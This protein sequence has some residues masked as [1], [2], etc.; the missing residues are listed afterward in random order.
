VGILT[1]S[2]KKIIKIP[3]PGQ[4]NN[5]QNYGCSLYL[6]DQMINSIHVTVVYFCAFARSEIF[7]KNA[8]KYR[9]GR[10]QFD[11]GVNGLRKFPVKNLHNM[12]SMNCKNSILKP[13][14]SFLLLHQKSKQET[15]K[16][17]NQVCVRESCPLSLCPEDD[18][19][20]WDCIS[21]IAVKA[22]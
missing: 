12:N 14:L 16:V 17:S 7:P 2:K 15:T 22:M 9:V 6:K 5:G 8:R 19:I 10:G 13:H 11:A 18:A 21:W 4:K 20:F 3:T 1:F